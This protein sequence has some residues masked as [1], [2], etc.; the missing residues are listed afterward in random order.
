V[1]VC[2]FSIALLLLRVSITENNMLNCFKLTTL[3]VAI[4]FSL[5]TFADEVTTLDALQVTANRTE[6]PRE[7]TLASVTIITREQIEQSQA[8]DVIDLLSKQA[9]L[10]IARSGGPGSNNAIFMRG[11]N[12][13]HTLILIDGVRSNSASQGVF[14][15]A[16]LPVAMIERI[17]IVRGP[18]AALWGSDAIGG[19]IQFFTRSPSDFAQLSVGS[20]GRAAIDVGVGFGEGDNNFGLSAGYDRL[21]GFSATNSSNP[22][23]YDP[24]KDGYRNRHIQM[25]G[26]SLL[27]SQKIGFSGI[28]TD[29]D[30]EFD[31]GET[32][33][34]NNEFSLGLSGQLAE[35][36]QHSLTLG[37]SYENLETVSEFYGSTYGSRRLALDW[38]NTLSL[39][40]Q[41]T[42]NVGLNWSRETAHSTDIFAGPQFN[43]TRRNT[44]LFASWR[45]DFDISTFELSVRHDNNSQF[46]SAT[47][48]QAA[49]GLRINDSARIRA[50]WGQGFRAPNFNELYYP[51]FV[52]GGIPYYAGNPDLDPERS[53]SA[54][55]GGLF[56]LSDNQSL[57]VSIYR[58]RVNNLVSFQGTNNQAININRAELD[59]IEADYRWDGERMDF[60]INAGWQDARDA[61]TDTKL[62][63][64][65]D[66]KLA[67]S[68]DTKLTEKVSFGVDLQTASERP[69]FSVSAGGY[70]R[71]DSRLGFQLNDNWNLDLRIE[72]VFNRDYE[73]VPGYSTPSRSG[74]L[75]LRWN[76]KN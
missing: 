49:W 43:E 19:V 35:H 4:S 41:N 74:M 7:K 14:D 63:R 27:G 50:S 75:T 44:G 8:P 31:Q 55:L 59:G 47:T 67:F 38:I 2:L 48:A 24:D 42:L 21:T 45:G 5:P 52:F 28:V 68:V 9:G 29:A 26:N 58:T 40:D 16:H 46:D 15:L 33:V 70:A 30:V 37:Q 36:W 12:S 22:F 60:K 71:L 51:G 25:R 13:N 23:G 18:R 62:L 61:D 72:N 69:D 34:S 76:G 17:E 3:A 20:Y 64:R 32:A 1:H 53:K 66:R 54:E 57:E 11:S 6:I 39:N 65:A 56:T 73:L 10:D